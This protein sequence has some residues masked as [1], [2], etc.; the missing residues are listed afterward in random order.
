MANNQKLNITIAGNT[1]ELDKSLKNINAALSNSKKEAQALQKDLKLDPG[2]VDIVT[3]R[4]GELTQALKLS[5]EKTKMLKDE[6]KGIDPDVDP[7]AFFKL[8]KAVNAAEREARTLQRQFDVSTATLSRLGSMSASFKFNPGDGVREFQNSLQGVNAALSTLGNTKELVNFNPAKATTEQI[9]KNIDKIDKASELLT[10]KAGLLKSELSGIDV[11]VDPAAFEKI[12]QQ[13]NKTHDD[14]QALNNAKINIPVSVGSVDVEFGDGIIKFRNDIDGIKAAISTLGDMDDLLTF[15]AGSMSLQDMQD[16]AGKL[17]QA[18]GLTSQKVDVLKSNLAKIDPQ[19]DPS[20]FVALTKQISETEADLRRLDEKKVTVDLAINS[21]TY[22][23]RDITGRFSEKLKTG[24]TQSMQ[25][26]SESVQSQIGAIFSPIGERIKQ[27]VDNN[28]NPSVIS[29]FK[30]TSSA[31]GSSL[32]TVGNV[33]KHSLSRGVASGASS[34]EAEGS[35][36][37]SGVGSKLAHALG[38]GL[39]VGGGALASIGSGL[40]S[41][42]T[43]AIMAPFSAIG[44]GL[45]TMLTGG[46][47]TVGNKITAGLGNAVSGVV[48]SMQ[49]AS[50]AGKNLENVLKFSGV[51]DEVIAKIK[52]DLGEYATTTTFASSS[53]NKVVGSL[54]AAGV[55][56]SKTADLTKALGNSYA[57]LGDGSRD[58]ADIGVIFSQINSATKLTAEDFNQLRDAGIGGALKNEIETAFPDIIKQFG[59]FS[60]AMSEGAISA[61]MVNDAITNIGNSDAATKAATIPKTM[62]DAFAG[63]NETIGQKLQGVFESVNQKG[64]DLIQSITS[65]IDGLDLSGIAEKALPVIDS[66]FGMIGEKINLISSIFS[67]IDFAGFGEELKGI[68]NT[69]S[70]E[71]GE[72]FAPEKIQEYTSGLTS[73]LSKIGEALSDILNSVDFGE[74][75]SAAISVFDSLAGVVAGVAST[76]AGIFEDETFKKSLSGAF[77]SVLNI[78]DDIAAFIN[79]EAFQ[80]FAQFL[81]VTLADALNLVLGIVDDIT[82]MFLDLTTG[83]DF[84]PITDAISTLYDVVKKFLDSAL[85]P[86]REKIEELADNGTIQSIWKNLGKL[87]DTFKALF[88][89]MEPVTTLI[90]QLLGYLA[91][92]IVEIVI[93]NIAMLAK[94]IGELADFLTEVFKAISKYTDSAFEW[95]SGIFG[96][97]GSSVGSASSYST[98][99]TVGYSNNNTTTNNN[100]FNV[101]APA[102]M[103][104]HG[105]AREIRHSFELGVV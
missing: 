77:E 23:I 51:N 105:L 18:I 4:H 66:V 33:I 20:G 38:K 14:L 83:L 73:A 63:M 11:N 62:G 3:K 70:A 74:I 6:M 28:I 47:L 53:L 32:S 99:S 37:F 41:K 75:L 15:D 61:D 21:A 85:D 50:T 84:S 72:I 80:S 40:G 46:L 89:F 93:T 81:S 87:G 16:K 55:E 43:S 101:T 25:N 13:L 95:L 26:V 42:L 1:V 8:Q 45:N 39:S 48:G 69:I 44:S 57:L 91:S 86:V 56:A 35:S 17:T 76:I 59:S 19:V 10:R 67:N 52:T 88:K 102:G 68:Y 30:R 49:E 78:L 103:N 7:S 100:V 54:S 96:F 64:I 71:F 24:L 34:V 22:N 90:G 92:E 79:G 27:T 82:K 5:Q 36:K 31:V 98:Y 58:I 65:K 97:E 2:N 104:V 12:Q 94:G 9:A 60:N 29:A